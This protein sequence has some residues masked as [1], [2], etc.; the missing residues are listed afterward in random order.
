MR[1]ILFKVLIF[2][3]FE[4]QRDTRRETE[5][6]EEDERKGKDRDR[7]PNG[8]PFVHSPNAPAAEAVRILEFNASIPGGWL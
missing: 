8:H 7:T 3:L 5:R 1:A 2:H 6:Q 4:R